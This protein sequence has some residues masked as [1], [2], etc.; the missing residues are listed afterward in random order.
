MNKVSD[1]RCL[2]C[3]LPSSVKHI[4][5]HCSLGTKPELLVNMQKS[6]GDRQADRW[7]DRQTDRQTA[8]LADKEKARENV[9]S[10]KLVLWLIISLKVVLKLIC[11]LDL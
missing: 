8:R 1:E 9:F 10:L 5:I 7:I 3:L 2:V 11:I 6:D 4:I